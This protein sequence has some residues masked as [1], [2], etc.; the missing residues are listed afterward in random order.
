MTHMLNYDIHGGFWKNLTRYDTLRIHGCGPTAVSKS[1]QDYVKY[2]WRTRGSQQWL[3][4][5]IRRAT[6]A[7]RMKHV[8]PRSLGMRSFLLE[9]KRKLDGI[10]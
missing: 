9:L 10:K 8:P 1:L 2:N 5:P 7:M 4:I 3:C 6:E